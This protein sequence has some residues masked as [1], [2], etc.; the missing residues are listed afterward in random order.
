[1]IISK[2]AREKKM[3][4]EDIADTIAPAKVAQV[5]SLVDLAER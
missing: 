1:M 3:L 2:K 5:L 4:L